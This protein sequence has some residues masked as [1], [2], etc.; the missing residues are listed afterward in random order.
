MVQ[1]I[2]VADSYSRLPWSM[3]EVNQRIKFS[4]CSFL[5]RNKTMI[6]RCPICKK[7]F[8]TDKYRKLYVVPPNISRR[9]VY[10]TYAEC[11]EIGVVARKE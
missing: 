2:C 7:L 3:V 11:C 8:D 6:F 4:V 1:A 10:V 9:A 5:T